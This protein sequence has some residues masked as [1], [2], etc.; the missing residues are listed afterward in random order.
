MSRSISFSWRSFPGCGPPD[1][2]CLPCSGVSG[3]TSLDSSHGGVKLVSDVKFLSLRHASR[4]TAFLC[5][6]SPSNYRRS[7]DYSRQKKH[8][9]SH[10]GKRQSAE[11]DG[12]KDLEE[13]ET[14]SSKN[15]S[16]LSTSGSQKFQATAAPGPR[17]KEIV[18]LFRKVQAKLRE[19]ASMKEEKKLE[20]PQG[21]GKE[22]GLLMREKIVYHR[23]IEQ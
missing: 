20:D 5:N 19:R 22:N 8:G 17:E 1:S 16:L 12:F 11:K 13:S 7:S 10:N 9:Y 14:Y 18:E 4:R 6:A 23:S 3:K 21:K 15:G 2:R